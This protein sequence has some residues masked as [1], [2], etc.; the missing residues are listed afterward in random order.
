MLQLDRFFEC[1]A[2][3]SAPLN[4]KRRLLKEKRFCESHE[5][6]EI[7]HAHNKIVRILSLKRKYTKET[8]R[9]SVNLSK[10]ATLTLIN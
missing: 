8:L 2:L 3:K 1:S 5:K 9:V 6:S 4:Q 10:F 7:F